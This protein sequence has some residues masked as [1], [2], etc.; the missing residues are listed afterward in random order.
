MNE[1]GIN[2][3]N[4]VNGKRVNHVEGWGSLTTLYK[5][6]ASVLK[7][8]TII[9]RSY[10]LHTAQVTSG[11]LDTLV[12]YAW[13]DTNA[14]V[15]VLEVEGNVVAGK[16]AMT[17]ATYIDT[18][19][20]I[21]PRALFTYSPLVPYYDIT[22]FNATISFGNLSASTDSVLWGFGD[23]STTNVVN[24]TH[25]FNCP[26]LQNVKLIAV[27]KTCSPYQID[28]LSIPLH[29]TDS[30]N[31][32]QKTSSLSICYVDSVG[33]HGDYQKTDGVYSKTY[34][35]L[36]G[37]DSSITVTLNV[38]SINKNVTRILGA[39]TSNQTNAS[40][41]WLDCNNSYSLVPNEIDISYASAVTGSYAVEV[42]KNSCVDTSFC[43]SVIVTSVDNLENSLISTVYPNPSSSV[44]NV[45][46][47]KDGMH[48][49]KVISSAGSVVIQHRSTAANAK[50]DLSDLVPG[51]YLLV[52]LNENSGSEQKATLVK[53]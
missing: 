39:L 27:N 36:N 1:Q 7:V 3:K 28:T 30:T 43:E 25:T 50:L 16:T 42:S 44:V 8:K 33:I 41:K 52:V 21:T 22:A 31:Y 13:F 9:Y 26:G 17:K 51:I 15:P 47:N 10:S 46:M 6:Y 23:E 5:T 12:K 11:K 14:G 32:F 2:F 4:V 29:I 48:E 35:A 45:Q 20:C 37:C 53:Q 40:Y 24:P 34:T 19:R 18:V 49:F 38:T